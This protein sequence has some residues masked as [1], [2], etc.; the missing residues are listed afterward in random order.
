L[1]D[2]VSY[3]QYPHRKGIAKGLHPHSTFALEMQPWELAF[4]EVVPRARLREPVALGA[5]W[6]RD[7]EGRMRIAPDAGVAQVEVLEPGGAASVHSVGTWPRQGPAGEIVARSLKALPK[8]EW[9]PVKGNPSPSVGFDVECA[10]TTPADCRRAQIL[11]L[12]RFP[13]RAHAPS[14]CS[15]AVNGQPAQLEQRVSGPQMGYAGGT[16]GFDPRSY[17]AGIIPHQC[18]WTW[19]LCEVPPGRARVR[20]RGAAARPDATFG[21]WLW[22]ERDCA[23]G[24][25]ALPLPCTAPEMPQS[26]D[27]VERRGVCLLAPVAPVMGC[28][29]PP[30]YPVCTTP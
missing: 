5:R 29:V 15:A 25:C 21:L 26:R 22:S 13:G 10:V 17:W 3:T 27:L 1:S 14:T 24:Q 28:D 23:A 4:V 6:Y 12:V 9:L 11:L 18:E 16:H 8:G 7:A 30:A 20:L 2:A 19:Y